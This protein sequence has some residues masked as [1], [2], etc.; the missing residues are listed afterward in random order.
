MENK[1]TKTVRH[2]WDVIE[3]MLKIVPQSETE[4]IKALNFNLD[5]AAYKAPE[6]TIQWKRTSKT[7]QK[8]IKTPVKEWEIRVLAIYLN[9][10]EEEMLKALK[11][12]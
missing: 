3:R 6:E 1:E 2:C 9:L 11:C 10:N 8:Y 5:Y 7:L 4:L 12:G